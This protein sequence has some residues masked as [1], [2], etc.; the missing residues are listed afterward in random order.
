MMEPETAGDPITG[1]KWTRRTT[2][3]I[4]EE[5]GSLG[6]AVSPNTVARLLKLFGFSLRVNRKRIPM[7]SPAE[8]DGQ[9]QYIKEQR[10]IFAAEQLP[11]VSVDTKKKELIGNFKNAGATWQ[12][13]PIEVLDH[14]FR[15]HAQGIAVP[16][17]VLDLQKNQARVLVG[18]SHDTAAFAVD[19]IAHWWTHEGRRTHAEADHLLILADS[20]GSNGARTRAWKY[21]LQRKLCDRFDLAVT[22]CHYPAGASKWNPID[23]RLFA[24]ISRNWQGRPLDSLPTILN[25]IRTTTTST[26]L[27]VKASVTR[28]RYLKGRKITDAQMARLDLH[29]HDVLPRWNYSLFPYHAPSLAR[30]SHR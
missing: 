26:G 1:L 23:H 16:Y 18:L 3:S 29:P 21:E 28:R 27:K 9:F 14:D 6:I 4:S 15:S 22:V 25:Y 30:G 11:V 17:G 2:R 8:R 24:Q 10:R 13:S 19:A 5:L 20:G 7:S 12:Q